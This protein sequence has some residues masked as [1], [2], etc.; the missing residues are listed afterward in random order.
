MEGSSGFRFFDAL[1]AGFLATLVLS[2]IMFLFGIDSMKM[3][4]SMLLGESASPLN[5]YL[6]GG[7]FHFAVGIAYGLLYAL[8]IAPISALNGLF[9]A[10]LFSAILTG[11]SYF[12]GP[13]LPG[14]IA[15]VE[16]HEMAPATQAVSNPTP[17]TQP[18]CECPPKNEIAKSWINHFVYALVLA[19]LY[20][21]N[22][23]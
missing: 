11:I 16:G 9:K 15:K 21:R 4:G 5:T 2:G 12:V 1:K 10:L 7:G 17:S 14:I 8:V 18:V 23:S 22:Q 3:L 13:K 20:R 19:A 6:A